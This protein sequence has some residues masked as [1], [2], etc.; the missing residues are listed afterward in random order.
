M[1]DT[2]QDRMGKAAVAF[3]DGLDGD[4]RGKAQFPFK[5]GGE[6]E[7]WFY[8]PSDPGGLRLRDMTSAQQRSA[9]QL[10]ATGLSAGGYVTTATI[11]GLENILDA[12]E[13]F[14]WPLRDDARQRDPMSYAVSIFGEPGGSGP[15]GWRF[16]GHHV[17]HNYLV[18][19]EGVRA[20]PSFFGA[21]HALHH[22]T[23]VNV[24]RALAGEED[25]G[26]A[27]VRMLSMEQRSRAIISPVAPP[28]VVTSNRPEIADGDEARPFTEIWR[29]RQSFNPGD[30]R[31]GF[32]RLSEWLGLTSEHLRLT[33]YSTEPKGLPVAAMTFEQRQAT[34]ELVHQYVDRLPEELAT[35]EEARVASVA[36]QL[37]FAWAGGIDPGEPHYY[38]LQGTGLLVE[39][40]NTQTQANHIHSV[41]RDPTSDFGRDL[42]AEHYAEAHSGPRP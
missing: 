23:G 2:L 8:T 9:H 38:R 11:M 40:D 18:A 29:N 41:W 21:D 12:A 3:L 1:S 7:Q 42:L 33:A 31:V 10:L 32:Q 34:L 30:S 37:H 5:A 6:R 26:R 16:G 4:R 19:P 39:Y 25:L 14:L 13:G 35:A 28:D 15:W 20:L 36:E 27:L 17:S 24:L 22:G